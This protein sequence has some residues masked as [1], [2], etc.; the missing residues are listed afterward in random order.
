MKFRRGLFSF[1]P[2]SYRMVGW[3]AHKILVTAQRPNSPFLLDL[4]GTGT[5]IWTGACQKDNYISAIFL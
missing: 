5:E 1:M 3:V 4:T 2:K